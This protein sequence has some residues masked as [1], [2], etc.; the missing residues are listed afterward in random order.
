MGDFFFPLFFSCW[1]HLLREM[2]SGVMWHVPEVEQLLIS[3]ILP[4]RWGGGGQCGGLCG[5]APFADTLPFLLGG[6]ACVSNSPHD[7]AI[8]INITRA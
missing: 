5:S 8:S 2:R 7:P 3:I 1:L 4:A 6:R